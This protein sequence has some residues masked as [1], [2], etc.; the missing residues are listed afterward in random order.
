MSNLQLWFHSIKSFV[1]WGKTQSQRQCE[2]Q[3]SLSSPFK[4]L[5]GQLSFQDVHLRLQLR[6]FAAELRYLPG[7]LHTECIYTHA[8]K[9][10]S[11]IWK[12]KAF[13]S[14]L[15]VQANILNLFT[16]CCQPASAYHV[17]PSAPTL[18]HWLSG[19]F[20]TPCADWWRAASQGYGRSASHWP[21][22]S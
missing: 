4:A 5:S 22:V 11:A 16:F 21:V 10:S 2:D 19:G 20:G 15:P 8:N 17:R 18:S 12:K 13:Y 1:S 9:S 14:S 3:Q 6:Y 7:M